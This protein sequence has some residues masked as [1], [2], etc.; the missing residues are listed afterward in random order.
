MRQISG[1]FTLIELVLVIALIGILATVAL[2][3]FTDL[4][5]ASRVAVI[6]GI[7]ASMRSAAGIVKSKALVQGLKVAAANPG[8]SSQTGYLVTTEAGTSE[9]DWRNLCPESRAELG[10]TL[11]MAD[12]IDLS[13]SGDLAV[14]IDNRYTRVGYDIRGASPPYTAGCYVVYDSFGDPAC[15]VTEV[16]VDC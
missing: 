4:S 8:G 13:V 11:T 1:G 12:H 15:T 2:P 6:E 5:S 9:V 14:I 7:A 16:T 3:R 10:D